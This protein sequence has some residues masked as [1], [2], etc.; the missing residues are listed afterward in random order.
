MRV[1]QLYVQVSAYVYLASVLKAD[2]HGGGSGKIPITIESVTRFRVK[3]AQRAGRTRTKLL[4][5]GRGLV[6]N[7]RQWSLNHEL[8]R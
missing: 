6:M 8:G 2:H 4:C 1:S 7:R 3:W 5:I